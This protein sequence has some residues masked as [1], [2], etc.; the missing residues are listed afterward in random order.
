MLTVLFLIFGEVM[1]ETYD[2]QHAD[3]MALAI[4]PCLRVIVAFLSPV[5]HSLNMVISRTMKLFGIQ[6]DGGLEWGASEEALRGAAAAPALGNSAR[7]RRARTSSI[8]KAVSSRAAHT[9]S[10]AL[11][12]RSGWSGSARCGFR[13]INAWMDTASLP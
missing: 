12:G 5:T 4:A 3:K 2:L 10:E 11:Y 13:S 6:F 8:F 9:Q 1:P 7:G